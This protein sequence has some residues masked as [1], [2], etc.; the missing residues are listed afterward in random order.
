MWSI[1]RSVGTWQF[2]TS[3]ADDAAF[4]VSADSSGG[5]YVAGFT[6]GGTFPGHTSKGSVDAFLAKFATDDDKKK[7]HDHD[8]KKKH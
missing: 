7:H 6:D 8:A 3:E 5:V 4:G 2:G 1:R